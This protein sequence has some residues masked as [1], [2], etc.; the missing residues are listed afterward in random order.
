MS[1]KRLPLSLV[2]LGLILNEDNLID[3]EKLIK[4]VHEFIGDV[5]YE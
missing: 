5:V 1:K 2:L 4:N 3:E